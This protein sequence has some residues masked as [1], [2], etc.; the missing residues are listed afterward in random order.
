MIFSKHTKYGSGITLFGDYWDFKNLHHSIHEL[1]E[2]SPLN[3]HFEDF[4]L[5]LAYDVRHAYQGMRNV[6]TFGIDKL[7]KVKYYGVSIIWP[8][9]LVQVALLRWA[10]SFK[11]TTKEIQ[12]NLYRLETCAEQSLLSYE[13][14]V[15]TFCIEWL[16]SFSGFPKNYHAEFVDNCARTYIKQRPTGKKRFEHLPEILKMLSPLSREYKEFT[17]YLETLAKEKN[18]KP[19]DLTSVLEE[20]PDFKW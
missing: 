10:A 6:R 2:D 11:S 7:Q 5:A 13:P 8:V 16:S 9:F 1:C 14:K 3:G 4:T 15:A 17:I 12:A 19:E 18:C 20:W